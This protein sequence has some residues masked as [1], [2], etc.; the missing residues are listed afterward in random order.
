MTIMEVTLLIMLALFPVID[1]LLDK[2]WRS[3]KQ[4]EYIKTAVMLWLVCGFLLFCWYQDTLTVTRLPPMLP[5]GVK[6]YL[7]GLLLIGL[8]SYIGYVVHVIKRTETVRYH[9]AQALSQGGEAMHAMLPQSGKDYALFVLVVSVSAGI[10]EE[11]IFRWYLY[12]FLSEN[13]HWFYALVLSSVA[14]GLWHAYLGW[15]HV[16]KTALVGALLCGVYI[17]IESLI[18]VIALHILLDIY[19]GTLAYVVHRYSQT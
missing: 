2:Y 15:Q 8:M 11:L 19:A 3:T 9:V 10:C 14:F 6:S 7:A 18:V 1:W 13:F 5:D 12:S 4:T 16:M 17:Y